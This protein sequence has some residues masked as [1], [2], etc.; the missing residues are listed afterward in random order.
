MKAAVPVDPQKIALK[1]VPT[2]EPKRNE[3]LIRI[4]LAG[5]F[6]SDHSLYHGK[7]QVPLPAYKLGPKLMTIGKI[8]ER[9]SPLA[10][11]SRPILR[12]LS[13]L[14]GESTKIFIIAGHKRLCLVREKGAHP[15]RYAINEGETMVLHAGSSGKVLLAYAPEAFHQ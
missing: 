15:L 9:T 3:V 14:T 6:G 2:P 13:A 10:T 7:F 4:E 8:Y 5:I 11:I 12:E 1:Q